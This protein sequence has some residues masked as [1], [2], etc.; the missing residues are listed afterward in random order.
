MNAAAMSAAWPVVWPLALGAILLSLWRHGK[1]QRVVAVLGS[2]V[3]VVL[4][5]MLLVQSLEGPVVAVFGGWKPPF[6]IAFV[7][8]RLG[9]SM[10]LITAIIGLAVT[11]YSLSGIDAR[12]EGFG[13]HTLVQILLAGVCGAFLTGDFFNLYVW[14]EVMLM[15]SFVLLALGGEK[16]QMMGALQYV[17]LN[18]I[19]STA[20]LIALGLLFGLVGTLN[21]ADVARQL[22]AAGQPALA[23]TVCSLLLLAFGV[24]AAIF[25]V[26]VWLPSSYHTPPTV[27]TALFAGLLTK[28]GVYAL[29]RAST[30]VFV[31]SAPFLMPLLLTL[32]ILTMLFG[33]L[34]A[35]AQNEYRRVLSFHIVSQIGYMVLGLA[36]LT[37]VGLAAA[38]FYILHHILVK[39]NLFLV[40][41]IARRM[42][43]SEQLKK[44][45]GLYARSPLL[46][47]LFL[48][49]AMSLAGLPPL[50]GFWAKL[51][52]LKAGLDSQEYVAV[53][54]A[55][56]V[57]LLT[58]FSMLKLWNEVFW[59]PMPE[60]DPDDVHPDMGRRLWRYLPVAGLAAGTLAFGFLAGPIYRFSEDSAR[61]LLERDGYVEAVLGV[62]K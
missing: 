26:Y 9:A 33:V 2:I 55:A 48:I 30:L 46:S 42:C 36:L 58:L 10:A 7:A 25:P 11:I 32:G 40:G 54:V 18:L 34:G 57:G 23:G 53:G 39:T 45:G 19:A 15:A 44:M 41:G 50:S 29:I 12:R 47:L 20:F 1:I 5:G 28:V 61:E 37:P 56:A 62:G 16:R 43:H 6:G 60:G 51:F 4:A 49:P 8:D 35:V 27:V 17:A 38:V 13:Y 31:D 3:H 59:K 52:V 22:P 14:F 21:M 24:K